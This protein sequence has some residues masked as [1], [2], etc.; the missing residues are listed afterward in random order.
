MKK[1][2]TL[3]L[4]VISLVVVFGLSFVNIPINIVSNERILKETFGN[5]GLDKYSKQ[6][7]KLLKM[8]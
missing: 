3:L 1:K 8:L 6:Y 7:L 2:L 4:I 5:I